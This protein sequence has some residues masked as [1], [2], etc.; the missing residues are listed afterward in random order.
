M[1]EADSTPFSG[2]LRL[3]CPSTRARPGMA[4][5]ELGEF[6]IGGRPNAHRN[7]SKFAVVVTV[8]L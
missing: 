3:E 7:S 8:V 2:T 4:H 5:V 6:P 1:L